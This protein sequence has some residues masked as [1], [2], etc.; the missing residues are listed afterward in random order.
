MADRL[1]LESDHVEKIVRQPL[2]L[3]V[4]LGFVEAFSDQVQIKFIILVDEP[5]KIFVFRSQGTE[6]RDDQV[7]CARRYRG[8]CPVAI[9]ELPAIRPAPAP[10]LGR[11][12]RA[13]VRAG[14]VVPAEMDRATGAGL[15][16][17]G[18]DQA[19]GPF[20]RLRRR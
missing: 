14:V 9:L 16:L 15:D 4:C 12:H 6:F 19:D 10:S 2:F 11:L 3:R 5:N 7:L 8:V 20:A 18:V 13:P 17:I 1:V